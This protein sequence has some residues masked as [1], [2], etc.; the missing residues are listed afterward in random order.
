MASLI[1]VQEQRIAAAL[2]ELAQRLA[3][4]GLPVRLHEI[5]GGWQLLTDP[6]Y[7]EVVSRLAKA[8]TDEKISPAALETLAVIAYRQ[9]VTKAEVEAIRG[10]QVAPVIRAL[11]DR[12]LVRIVGRSQDPGHALLYGTTQ[13][14]L[15]SFSLARLEDLPRDSELVAD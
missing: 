14:F 6:A 8:R 7:S 10:V 3:G 1:E 11:V 5:A 13:R 9:P 15:G 4:A 12:G 2:G